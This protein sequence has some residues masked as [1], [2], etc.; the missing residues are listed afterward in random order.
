MDHGRDD[1]GWLTGFRRQRPRRRRACRRA[2]RPLIPSPGLGRSVADPAFHPA[3]EI[4]IFLTAR[5]AADQADRLQVLAGFE[6]VALLDMPH[7]VV[8]PRPHVLRID[9]ECLVVPHLGEL[10]IAELALG[11]AD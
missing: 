3:L 5:A 11:I 7:A 6:H 2:T 1:A 10:I 9:G 8:L 4:L